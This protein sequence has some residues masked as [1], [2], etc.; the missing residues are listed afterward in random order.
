MSFV[1][2]VVKAGVVGFI[3]F[4][5]DDDDDGEEDEEEDVEAAPHRADAA[6]EKTAKDMKCLGKI[7][8]VRKSGMRERYY[9]LADDDDDDAKRRWRTNL[10]R[11]N[12]NEHDCTAIIY[13]YSAL[14][15]I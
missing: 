4:D 14:S 2:V 8:K 6:A 1:V 7:I 9:Y 10:H 3:F 12:I 13:I 11:L 15:C 5:D